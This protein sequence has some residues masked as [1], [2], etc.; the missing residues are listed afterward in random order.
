MPEI[1]GNL[2]IVA[3]CHKDHADCCGV[4]CQWLRDDG[5][6]CS[7]FGRLEMSE[8]LLKAGVVGFCRHEACIRQLRTREF[9]KQT[10]R[11]RNEDN[12]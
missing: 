5:A 7:L 6:E 1:K 3:S 4:D 2:V 10:K 11:W 9:Y 12:E 8:A